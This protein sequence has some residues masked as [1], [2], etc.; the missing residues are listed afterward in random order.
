MHQAVEYFV[1]IIHAFETLVSN[2]IMHRDF[3]LANVLKHN[4]V[5]KIADFGFSKLLAEEDEQA[6]TIL[7]SPLHMAPEIL[8]HQPYN[9]KAD[10]WSLGVAFYE[11]I[12][13]EVPFKA[14]NLIDLVKKINKET[15]RFPYALPP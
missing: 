2:K 7:G 11:M 10:I 5:I 1:Q 14:D 9:N 15:V 13:G 12:F 4:G 6:E 3:K 8:N